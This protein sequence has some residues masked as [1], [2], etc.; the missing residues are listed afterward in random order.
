MTTGTVGGYSPENKFTWQRGNL[1]FVSV[2]G[3]D[4]ANTP[5]RSGSRPVSGEDAGSDAS[6]DFMSGTNSS[7]T[8]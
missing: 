7:G 8:K 2:G 6:A 4:D 1:T 5:P 3:D